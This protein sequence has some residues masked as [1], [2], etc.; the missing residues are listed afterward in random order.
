MKKKI[1]K[2]LEGFFYDTHGNSISGKF[3]IYEDGKKWSC[4]DRFGYRRYYSRIFFTARRFGEYPWIEVP[5][6]AKMR[7]QEKIRLEDLISRHFDFL[8]GNPLSGSYNQQLN[9]L[10]DIKKRHFTNSI[11]FIQEGL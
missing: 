3:H 4:K 8:S 7:I 2:K 5:K 10:L 11:S 6:N 9:E 1:Y